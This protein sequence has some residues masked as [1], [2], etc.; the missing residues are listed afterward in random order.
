MKG[1]VTTKGGHSLYLEGC[2]IGAQGPRQYLVEGYGQS[3]G[4]TKDQLGD[5]H[6]QLTGSTDLVR[7]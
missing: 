7:A 2:R 4:R 3:G 6:L 5:L 1:V